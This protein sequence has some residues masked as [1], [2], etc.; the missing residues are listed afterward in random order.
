MGSRSARAANGA[1]EQIHLPQ[2]QRPGPDREWP[3]LNLFAQPQ[4]APSLGPIAARHR[5]PLRRVVLGVATGAQHRQPPAVSGIVR[6][7]RYVQQPVRLPTALAY[8]AGGL[9][10]CQPGPQLIGHRYA[11]WRSLSA[12]SSSVLFWAACRLPAPLVSAARRNSLSAPHRFRWAAAMRR[13]AAALRVR[14]CGSASTASVA[15]GG[16]RSPI[17]LRSSAM[18]SSRPAR[19]R[20]KPIRA[21]SSSYGMTTSV[22]SLAAVPDP[23]IATC[24]ARHKRFLRPAQEHA[25]V[26]HAGGA[27][28]SMTV[29]RAGAICAACARKA[30]GP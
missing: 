12:R 25:V 20:S 14:L 27:P 7:V 22:V 23:A 17:L 3:P 26:R 16:T 8:V 1:L 21:A 2:S 24:S 9:Q 15:R 30:N 18:R 5:Q 4:L 19:L 29:I 6:E 28:E 11:S 10:G 13:R